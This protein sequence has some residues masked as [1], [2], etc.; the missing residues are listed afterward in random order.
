MIWVKLIR[1]EKETM[2]VD[3]ADKPD[4]TGMF[5]ADQLRNTHFTN[6]KPR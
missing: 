2:C 5:S 6:K 3:F 1:Y 4:S